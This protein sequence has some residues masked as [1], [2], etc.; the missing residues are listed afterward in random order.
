M[1]FTKDDIDAIDSA[2]ASG[3]LSV[4]I[5]GRQLQY[6]SISELLRAKAH[7]IQTMSKRKSPFAG[8]RMTVDRGIR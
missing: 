5:D 2:I 6:R 4:L 7:I 1:A 8:Y 3:E